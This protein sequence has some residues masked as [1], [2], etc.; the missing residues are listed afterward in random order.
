MIQTGFETRV[1][2]QQIVEN[3]LPEFIL[4][5]SPKAAEFLK[6]YYI[7]QE[8]QGGPVD[9]VENLD[10]YLKLDNLTPEVI[11][12]STSITDA[13]DSD[14]AV[15]SVVSTKGFPE[16]Y[17]LFKIDDE[18]ITYTGITTNTFTG[19]I[20]GFSGITTY[21]TISD[22]QELE[23]STSRAA[24]HSVGSTIQNLSSLFLKEFYK[25]LKYSLTPG[26]EDVDFVS[27]LNIGNFIKE[28][29]SFYQ[30]KGTGESFRILFNVLYGITPSVINL[31]DFLI[32]PSAADYVRREIVVAEA[33]SGNPTKLVGQSIR[34]SSDPNTY[35]SI[36]SVEAIT[37]K[38]KTYYQISLFIGYDESTDIQ[39]TFSVQ[40]K[41]IVIEN[42]PIGSTIIT[43][44]S[45]IGFP[46]D[47]NIIC[48]DNT[49]TYS[50]K[51]INQFFDCSGIVNPISATD[52][53]RTDEI[54][55]G[56]ED[57][58]LSKEVKLRLTGVLSS[59]VALSET[60]TT[61]E[62]QKIYVKNLG[63][64][65]KNPTVDKSHK[66]IFANSWIYNTSSRYQIDSIS[67]SS[68]KLTSTIDKSSLK[69]D[70]NVEVLIRDSETV[71]SAS[72]YISNI[73]T[74]TNQINLDGL[75][76]FVYDPNLEYDVR[77][78]LFKASSSG[79]QLHFGNNTLVSDVQNVYN[80]DN[81]YMY[82]ASNSLP[83]YTITKN[84]FQI[85]IPE[86]SGSAI[87]GFNAETQKYSIIS[88]ASNVPFITGDQ[89]N[90]TA[91]STPIPGLDEG[92]YYV[93]VIAINQIKLYASKSF[94]GSENYVEF[95]ALGTGTGAQYFI[96]STQ[97]N[98]LIAPK[99]LLR[100]FPI[101]SNIKNGTGE[102]TQP[103]STGMLIN[104]VEITNY[105]SDDK[106]YYGPLE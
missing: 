92:L 103:G 102:L 85:S 39:G 96:L 81:E 7:S 56:Y 52:S 55:Y 71:V 50:S 70:D 28:A 34:K 61:E 37:R 4:D 27:D 67:G 74:T 101:N 1:K 23:F 18:I 88:F 93:E 97:K 86:A 45:T 91:E 17:G 12:G 51:S 31:E 49:I 104:G 105:K 21:N 38:G 106:I 68:F 36:S 66:E 6:Q 64:I 2:V 26:L 62:G 11:V 16:K 80:E 25:K 100:K 44:D 94:I 20:R 10:Q 82:V 22:P 69:V 32:K 19:C 33:I 72:P 15:I 58:N 73:N 42:A 13:I 46:K 98:Q 84:L 89:I 5:E 43:V 65:I 14:S 9:V 60:F 59:F 29:R 57:G 95:D 83:S 99:K 24:S 78:K 40:G 63:E 35:A 79:A 53:I 48:G 41:S 87:Q 77:R 8:Y 47:G 3:Q 76:G 30:A 90:Y 54:V 75:S